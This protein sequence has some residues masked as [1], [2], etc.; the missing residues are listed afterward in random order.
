MVNNYKLDLPVDLDEIKKMGVKHKNLSKKYADETK[1]PNIPE[2]YFN[3]I[4]NTAIRVMRDKSEIY[5]NRATASLSW[6]SWKKNFQEMEKTQLSKDTLTFETLL[7][8]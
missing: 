6:M 4:L 7:K 3:I 1:L 8:E 2:E 5:N